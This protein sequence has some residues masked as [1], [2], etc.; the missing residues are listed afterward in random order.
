MFEYKH[1]RGSL[2]KAGHPINVCIIVR[3]HLGPKAVV[4]AGRAM[5]PREPVAIETTMNRNDKRKID[6][7]DLCRVSLGITFHDTGSESL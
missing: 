2:P 4:K 3:S 7:A 1:G 6:E 5:K